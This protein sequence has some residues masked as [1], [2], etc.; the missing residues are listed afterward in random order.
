MH[1]RIPIYEMIFI[2]SY[3]TSHIL[4]VCVSFVL[5]VVL[6]IIYRG[7]RKIVPSVK[8]PLLLQSASKLA[9]DI[10]D[11]KCKSEDVI[12]A[13]I[14]RIQ[15]VEPYINATAERCF[16]D[17]LEKAK[18]VDALVASGKCTKEQLALEKPLLGIPVTIKCLFHV[19]DMP[20]T[21]GS[22]LFSDL[23]ATEDAPNVAAL[24][25][26]GAI[27]IA[28]SNAPEMG[29][30][31]ESKNR[32]YG[33]TC[34]PY[35]TTKICGGSSGGEAALIG[36]GASVLGL[37][38]DFLGSVR[39]PAHFTGVF[40]HKPTI[41]IMSNRGFL[42][43]ERPGVPGGF[44]EPEM[45]SFI[46]SGPICRYAEDL[47]T[48]VK[49]LTLDNE[50]RMKLDRPV[51]FKK[52]KIYYLLEI[53]S[54]MVVP[55]DQEIVAAIK[56]A[57]S[58]FEKQYDITPTEVKMPYL[59]DAIRCICTMLGP[60]FARLYQSIAGPK[61]LGINKKEEAMKLLV[62]KSKVCFSTLVN[63]AILTSPLLN[64]KGKRPYYQKMFETWMDEFKKLLDEDSVLLMPTLPVTAPYHLESY[65]FMPSVSYTGII[66]ALGLPATQCPLGL[67]K[68][69]LPYGIQI[70]GCKN[71][72]ALT[73][74][75]AV[76]LERAF[77]GW[78][79][80]EMQPCG[81]SNQV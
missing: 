55:V 32:L 19:K 18:E 44:W 12:Q 30:H 27:V 58:Y 77:G 72:D 67:D 4:L 54:L 35:D 13:Y 9:R 80:S 28:T 46:V 63:F 43:V 5:H 3:W 11:G 49:V 7:K 17:A 79:S 23:K 74:A 45:Y 76:E 73:I 51:D 60:T 21:A 29:L 22:L 26:A 48:S 37:G 8:N 38:N 40:A 57:A 24:K 42:P 25:K 20:C 69:G 68:H 34:N 33:R 53:R 75:C 10:R 31:I 52:V 65:P 2:I 64:R 39:L 70:V 15:E 59:F 50:V 47:I 1:F 6:A 56:N 71:N 41:G 16:E 62:G 36:A 61:G 81:V 78:K 66:S 14:D